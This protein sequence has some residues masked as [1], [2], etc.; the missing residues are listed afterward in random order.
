MIGSPEPETSF[1][2]GVNNLVSDLCFAGNN[3]KQSRFKFGKFYFLIIFALVVVGVFFGGLGFFDFSLEIKI[4]EAAIL[5]AA[6]STDT[7]LDQTSYTSIDSMT[8]TP[9]AGDYLAV[10]SM[11]VLFPSTAGAE[12]FRVAIYKFLAG[13]K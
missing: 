4:A 3:T 6:T 5:E 2:Y 10:F 11:D 9:G 8:L 12:F 1:R 13:R 7:T